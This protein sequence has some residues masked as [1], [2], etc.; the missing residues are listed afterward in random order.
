MI[1]RTVLAL[2]FCIAASPSL[3]QGLDGTWVNELRAGDDTI[4][5]SLTIA[6]GVYELEMVGTSNWQRGIVELPASDQLRLVVQEFQ[7]TE[8]GGQLLAQPPNKDYRIV[9]LSSSELVVLDNLCLQA[10]DES[11]CKFVWQRQ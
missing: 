1:C 9:S 6:T 8:Y 10:L 11:N 4:T 2:L 5:F 7:P 3:S